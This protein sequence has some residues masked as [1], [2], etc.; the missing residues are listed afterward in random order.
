MSML[1]TFQHPSIGRSAF[2]NTRQLEEQ[3]TPLF[4]SGGTDYTKGLKL[5]FPGNWLHAVVA[6]KPEVK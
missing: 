6:T 4:R 5:H 1:D 2:I 3:D